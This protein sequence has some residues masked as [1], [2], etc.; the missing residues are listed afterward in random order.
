MFY[1]YILASR[2][3]GTLYIGSTD[4]L[5]D[6]VR[7]HREATF[8]GFTAL[9]GVHTLVWYELHHS[10]DEAFVRERQLKKWKRAWKVGLIEERN[11]QW[12]DLVGEVT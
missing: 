7:Q 2:R 6:R 3:N 10:R 12:D 9:H 1:T 5:A 8:G 4:N 11:C